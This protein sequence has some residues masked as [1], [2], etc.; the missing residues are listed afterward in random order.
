MILI[1]KVLSLLTI[2]GLLV[3][4]VGCNKKEPTK[5][6]DNN[7]DSVN[8]NI[9]S[10]SSQEYP[11]KEDVYIETIESYLTIPKDYV[12]PEYNG[13]LVAGEWTGKVY[14]VPVNHDVDLNV[15]W[16]LMPN[17]SLNDKMEEYKGQDVW[18]RVNVDI[19]L[20]YGLMADGFTNAK[21]YFDFT[22][23][24]TLNYLNSIGAHDI[25][26]KFDDKS[27]QA[28]QSE[29]LE[30]SL[31]AQMIEML[32]G[33]CFE[34]SLG[35]YPRI[36]K[37]SEFIGDAL[38]VKLD[39]MK[40]SDTV[41][42]MVVCAADEGNNYAYAQSES[43]NTLYNIVHFKTYKEFQNIT[44]AEYN[45]KIEKYIL[46]ITDRNNISDKIVVSDDLPSVKMT[47]KEWQLNTRTTG[48]DLSGFR[49]GFNA[50]LT[51]AEI[52]KLAEDDEIKVIYLAPQK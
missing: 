39:K 32:S 17:K 51:K 15:I 48:S 13:R 27:E 36:S 40:N 8:P 4:T 43:V 42:V 28:W 44:H 11:P 25:K 2:I 5:T 24:E 37:Y 38:T 49:I 33:K 22:K 19:K 52:L 18:F 50:V 6:H 14:Y 23:S 16:E 29:R 41:E 26:T 30:V 7:I 31:T 9:S 10:N 34:L 21:K 45:K 35:T 3:L 1:K 20:S 47:G 12:K 46:D